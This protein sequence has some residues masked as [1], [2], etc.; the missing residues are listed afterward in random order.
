MIED[1]DIRGFHAHV[2]FD[3]GTRPTAERIHDALARR[4]D[5][6]LGRLHDRPLG[7]HP[8][9]MFEVELEPEHFATVVPWLMINR[10]GLSVLVHPTTDDAVADHA[11]RPL[12]MGEVLPL[13]VEL[14]RRW[15]EAMSRP[16][17]TD[18]T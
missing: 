3:A 7:P 15:V 11:T 10:A 6:K 9:P 12:W 1:T 4:F 17:T 8:K 2:Y 18:G 13:D 5:L 16:R 14:V